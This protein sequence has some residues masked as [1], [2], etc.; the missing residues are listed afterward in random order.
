MAIAS[1]GIVAIAS[2]GIHNAGPLQPYDL[3]EP[4]LRHRLAFLGLTTVTVFRVE[5]VAI[6]ELKDAALAKAR[7][8]LHG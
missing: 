5:G 8:A 1:G 6:S 4:C 7:A 3:T 2:G